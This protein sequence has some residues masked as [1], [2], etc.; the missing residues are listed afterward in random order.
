[1][2]GSPKAVPDR[3]VNLPMSACCGSF[4]SF[5]IS[6]PNV[7]ERCIE[8]SD[9]DIK[10][11]MTIKHR[12]SAP[13][14]N[15][16]DYNK[17]PDPPALYPLYEGP[18]GGEDD[19]DDPFN[20]EDHEYYWCYGRL[21]GGARLWFGKYKGQCIRDVSWAYLR[22]CRTNLTRS[23]SGFHISRRIY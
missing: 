17:D 10:N 18:V 5:L 15:P 6:L 8:K 22:C 12:Q 1:M 13:A 23:V 7:H 14:Y 9:L 20:D 4:H 3:R 2:I 16:Q 21:A 19:P 11:N